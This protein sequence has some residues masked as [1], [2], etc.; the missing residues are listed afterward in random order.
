MT[1]MAD[2]CDTIMLYQLQLIR[3]SA[4]PAEIET[5]GEIL[6]ADGARVVNIGAKQSI[7]V[8][9]SLG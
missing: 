9:R 5:H 4:R 7:R 2:G 3:C 1:V 8:M 6:V